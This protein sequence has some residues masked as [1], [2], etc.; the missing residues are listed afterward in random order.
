MRNA[1][2]ICLQSAIYIKKTNVVIISVNPG[3]LYYRNP[4]YISHIYGYN[5]RPD[6]VSHALALHRRK[7]GG[8]R[9][10]I[11]S[12][13]NNPAATLVTPRSNKI[14]VANS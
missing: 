3:S 12:I 4:R 13:T 9:G 2:P 8:E 7:N 10:C 1:L 5:Q 14:P 11:N 6:F